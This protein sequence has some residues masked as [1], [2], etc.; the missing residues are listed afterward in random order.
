MDRAEAVALAR[1][2]REKGYV[3]KS[4]YADGYWCVRHDHRGNGSGMIRTPEEAAAI[5]V[6]IGSE[7]KP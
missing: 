7:V 5:R 1:F 3:A 6:V 2:L 4:V